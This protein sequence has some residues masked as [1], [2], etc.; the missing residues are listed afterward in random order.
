[1]KK[2]DV[3]WSKYREFDISTFV[4]DPSNT[5]IMNFLK[6]LFIAKKERETGLYLTFIF[7]LYI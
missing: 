3:F 5:I 2:A 7:D 1:M 6:P 4:Y